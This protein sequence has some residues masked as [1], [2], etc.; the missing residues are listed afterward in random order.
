MTLENKILAVE[1]AKAPG[2]IVEFWPGDALCFWNKNRSGTA[3]HTRI[4]IKIL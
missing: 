3:D 1:L 4:N 2:R